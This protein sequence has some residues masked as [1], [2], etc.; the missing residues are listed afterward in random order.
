MMGEEITRAAGVMM[1]AP[2]GRILMLRSVDTGLWTFPGGKCEG[3]ETFAQAAVREVLEEVGYRLGTPGVEHCRRIK[4]DG[5]GLVDYVTF[6][7]QVDE[8]FK[9]RLD[10]E[11][12]SFAWL[13]PKDALDP[14]NK[15]Q[16][17]ASAV[18]GL[19][20]QGGRAALKPRRK[21]AQR[22]HFCLRPA[23]RAQAER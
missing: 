14:P 16:G 6:V 12:T 17:I 2:S 4:D 18:Q 23:R 7:R 11:N 15:L 10:N 1:V 19:V 13:L 3:D 8:E 5:A 22:A 9:P 21:A 20:A